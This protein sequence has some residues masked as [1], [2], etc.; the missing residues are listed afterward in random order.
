MNPHGTD[1]SALAGCPCA[2]CHER[3]RELD[4]LHALTRDVDPNQLTL[5]P[6]EAA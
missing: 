2:A 6:M 1:Q 5:F 3:R 4:V